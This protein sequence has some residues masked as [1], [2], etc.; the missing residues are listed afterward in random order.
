MDLIREITTTFTE[1]KKKEFEQFLVRKRPNSKRKDLNVF[2]S[3][4]N[5]Y[6]SNQKK[7]NDLIGHPNYHAIRK[8]IIKELLH[9]LVLYSSINDA[10]SPKK[11]MVLV[12][13]YFIDFKKYAAAWQILKKEE[14][15]ANQNK[16]YLLNLRIQRLKLE[17]LPYYNS[18]DFDSIKNK[19]ISLQKQQAKMD[20][21]QLC[22][23]QKFIMRTKTLIELSIIVRKM[24]LLQFNYL[25][26]IKENH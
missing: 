6:N 3:I 14:K 17:I 21:F 13:K 10:S 24:L 22:F 5:S 23:I 20:E 16:D 2:Q 26:D 9:F 4:Y 8:R 15:F 12:A 25:E 1:R 11:D 19:I 18:V 7:K